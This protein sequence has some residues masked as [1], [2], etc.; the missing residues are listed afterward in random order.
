MSKNP[1]SPLRVPTFHQLKKRFLDSGYE[2]RLIAPRE[3]ERLA[4]DAP[5]EAKRH[6]SG[7]VLGLIMPDAYVIGLARNQNTDERA[8][9]L[10]HELIHLYDES[11]E[12]ETVEALTEEVVASLSDN[13][14][15]FL[16]LLVA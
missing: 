5:L 4:L 2:V 13:D 7:D 3:L 10:V 11:M 12:E 6:M 16:Q 14:Y 1:T 9:T 8:E 15:R